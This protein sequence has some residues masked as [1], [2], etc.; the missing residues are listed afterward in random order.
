MATLVA[1]HFFD[2]TIQYNFKLKGAPLVKIIDRFE[3]R[4]YQY[5]NEESQLTADAPPLAKDT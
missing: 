5:L 1:S 2:I 4:Y 3:V